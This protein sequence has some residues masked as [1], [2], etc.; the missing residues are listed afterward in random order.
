MSS[1]DI[2]GQETSTAQETPLWRFS[3]A[4][5]PPLRIGL[6]L[7]S[8]KLARF[9]AQIVDDIQASNFAKI[10]LLVY[11]KA[12]RRPADGSQNRSHSGLGRRLLDAKSRKRLLYDFYLRLDKRLKPA[13]HPL[14]S[15]DCTER[16]AGIESIE[17]EPV[18]KKFVHR[19]P[20]DALEQIRSKDLD[21]LLRFGFN[22]LHGDIL[23]AARYGVWSYHHGDNDFYR[24]GP[25]HF[26]ELQ[27]GAPL[28]G[29]IL[30]VLTEEL[31]G[32]LVLCK[33]LFPTQRTLSMSANRQ[34]P[35]WG[36]THFVIRKLNELHQFGWEHL[37]KKAVPAAPYQ[38]K[39]K[40]YRTPTNM[41]IG[42]W[43]GPALLKKAV[44]Y[45]FRRPTVQHWRIGVRVNGKRLLEH[46]QNFE[47]FRWIN[48]PKGH[49]WADPFGLEHGG[50]N[51]A[52]FEDFSYQK[53]R[54]WI[55]CA[56]ISPDGGLISPMPCLDNPNEHYSYPHVFRAG[57]DLFMVPESWDA[58]RVEL[59]RCREFPN[60]WVHE[61]TLFHGKYVDT[62]IWHQDGRWWLLTTRADPDP[63]TGCLLLFYA[64]SL[65]GEWRFHPA[66]PIST[67]IRN[68]RGAGRVFRADGRWI[69]PSQTRIPIYGYSFALNEI[70]ALTPAEYSERVLLNVTPEHWK[71]LCAVHT[72]NR[73]GNIEL[74]DGARMTRLKDVG[75]DP[76]PQA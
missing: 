26:W 23:K 12:A 63:R 3:A 57:S 9:F 36:S 58:N 48:A 60:R 75:A 62:N 15:V 73:V 32:G 11:R 34:A 49:F 30:Q 69:R 6:L 56:E 7:D 28:S 38:G 51:W 22:I 37:Q 53:K 44:S 72:Y 47:G 27:E 55:S 45:P 24:G 66:N 76:D 10:E 65:D 35:Y 14:E 29:V 41:D 68:S 5:R 19:F 52:F 70:T 71:G 40:L 21:V 59:F 67:D 61:R 39:R 74:I 64:E 1:T 46:D 31:D 16:L 42:R 4:D 8:P 2:D 25:A 18:G 50:K 13:N 43:L 54:G 20:E 17:V 33:S